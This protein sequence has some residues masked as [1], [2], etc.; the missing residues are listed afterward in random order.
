MEDRVGPGRRP[1]EKEHA[2][3][4]VLVKSRHIDGKRRGAGPQPPEPRGETRPQP[5][6][7]EVPGKGEREPDERRSRPEEG[8]GLD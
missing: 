3:I 2:R 1:L 5:R 8:R 6:R 4:G 7:L